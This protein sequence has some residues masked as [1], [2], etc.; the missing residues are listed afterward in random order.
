MWQMLMKRKWNERGE[1]MTR[2]KWLQVR[3]EPWGAAVRTGPPY[4]GR[5]L[6]HRGAPNHMLLHLF[7]LFFSVWSIKPSNAQPWKMFLYKT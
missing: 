7:Q 4:M 6:T 2:S 1:G 5:M 3:L